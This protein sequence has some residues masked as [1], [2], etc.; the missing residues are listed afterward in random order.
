MAGIDVGMTGV[1]VGRPGLE[2]PPIPVHPQSRSGKRRGLRR[3]VW[4]LFSGVVVAA[5]SLGLIVLIGVVSWLSLL[6]E[7]PLFLDTY[8]YTLSNY[9]DVFRDPFL[10]EI[11]GNSI[12]FAVIAL[13]V[14]FTIGVGAAWLVERTN[15]RLKTSV[16][17]IMTLGMVMPGF[18]IA[19]GW[20]YLAGPRVG[21]ATA[22]LHDAT[23]IS[24]D[25]STI[26][27]MAL[28][29]GLLYAPVA[30]IMTSAAF[31]RVDG[32]MEE[33]AFMSG[34]NG[35]QTFRRVT[36][37]VLR[38]SL[39]GAGIYV[40]IMCFG[41]FDIPAIL[42]LQNRRFIFSTYIYE[43]I[44]P[45]V[46][47]RSQHQL[48][49][50][51]G[52]IMIIAG[53][54]LTLWYGRTVKKAER[55]ATVSG[56]SHKPGKRVLSR[57]GQATATIAV[58]AYLFLALVGPF[59]T[60]AWV[61]V[62]PYTMAPSSEAFGLVNL[63]HFRNIP[64]DLL[65][66]GLKNTLWLIVVVPTTVMFAVALPF[67][68]VV[69]R[70][71]SRLRGLADTAAFIPLV[72]PSIIFGL[73]MLLITLFAVQKILPLY[74]TIWAIALAFIVSFISFGSRMTNGAWIQLGRDLEESATMSGATTFQVVRRI[75]FP[76]IRPAMA[77]GWLW[78]ALLTYRQLAI[79]ALLTTPRNMTLP[80][81]VW[82]EWLG[83]RAGSAAACSLL[84]MVVLVPL[85]ALYWRFSAWKDVAH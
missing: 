20:L 63:D 7:P 17:T 85:I 18:L 28:I 48:A 65:W 47:G 8:E 13:A 78:I 1:A 42:G 9:V 14:A 45:N 22:A 66:A 32:A 79:P 67:S 64:W 19:L 72:V 52:M 62:T 71:K 33:A 83:G 16:Y 50:T 31:A 80:M 70:S 53:I 73:A 4:P 24:L 26:W 57:G 46:S 34:A 38:P 44:N 75:V 40:L 43:L 12:L 55:Y 60:L 10:R 37:P 54:M 74:G 21:F 68:W 6:P 58:F 11:I 2:T 30:F 61:A 59:L 5:V 15:F 27:G 82:G 23:G 69:L 56:K 84:F 81:V 39:I 51:F 41:T 25:F 35:W 49:A 29:Q 36:L 3:D 76:L 77:A